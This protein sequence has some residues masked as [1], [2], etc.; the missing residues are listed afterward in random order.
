MM[1]E[2]P[3]GFSPP[4]TAGNQSD[5]SG[6]HTTSSGSV[7]PTAPPTKVRAMVPDIDAR[8]MTDQN[9]CVSRVAATMTAVPSG[10]RK[11][12]VLVAGPSA[13]AED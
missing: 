2:N 9:G 6:T 5:M 8:E 11:E 4:A 10:A 3:T 7:N 12:V 1:R 13:N